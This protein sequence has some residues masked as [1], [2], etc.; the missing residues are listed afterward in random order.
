MGVFNRNGPP[1]VSSAYMSMLFLATVLS[2]G[3]RE[4][5]GNFTSCIKHVRTCIVRG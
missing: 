5:F 2:N 1:C 4:E 3:T